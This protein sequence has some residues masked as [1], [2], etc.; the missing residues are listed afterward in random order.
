MK[1]MLF[2]LALVLLFPVA[3][4]SQAARTPTPLI[5]PPPGNETPG[6]A[7]GLVTAISAQTITV[8]TEAAN[9]L[10]FALSKTIRLQDKKGKKIKAD[11]IRN[12]TRVRVYYEGGE[13]TRTANKIVVEG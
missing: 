7:K 12:G 10:S 11:R 1:P 3:G 2:A 13:E 5:T 9:P 8:K 6:I 4:F